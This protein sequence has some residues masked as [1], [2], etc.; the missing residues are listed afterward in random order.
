MN[1][2]TGIESVELFGGTVSPAVQHLIDV[3]RNALP[4]QVQAALWTAVATAP[5]QLPVYYML[6]KMHAGRGELDLALQA[7]SKG[8]AAAAQ[9]AQLSLDWQTVLPGATDFSV[10]GPARFWLFTLK[11]LAFIQL[12]RGERDSATALVARL[13]LLD[14]DDHLG[15]SVIEALLSEST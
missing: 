9:A 8:L 1:L 4:A 13:R 5:D 3:A 15:A 11:A 14:P 10:P 2:G 6:Y 7:A 12:R